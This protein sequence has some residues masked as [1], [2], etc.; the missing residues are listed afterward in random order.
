MITSIF[1]FFTDKA[2]CNS[3]TIFE[4]IGADHKTTNGR[5]LP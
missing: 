4:D 1:Q 3:Y 5:L 2:L